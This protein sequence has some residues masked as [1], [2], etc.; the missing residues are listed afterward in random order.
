MGVSVLTG[1]LWSENC[2]NPKFR[3]EDPIYV[4]L[5]CGNCRN[6]DVFIILWHFVNSKL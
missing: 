6:V 3:F 4:S 1:P 2:L 5:K